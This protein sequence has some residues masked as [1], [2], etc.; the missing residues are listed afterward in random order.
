MAEKRA[1]KINSDMRDIKLGEFVGLLL[2]EFMVMIIVYWLITLCVVQYLSSINLDSNKV[3]TMFAIIACACGL[4]IY[5]IRNK[6]DWYITNVVMFIA[7]AM[8][9]YFG[10]GLAIGGNTEVSFF[11]GFVVPVV[12]FIVL[13]I[14]IMFLAVVFDCT[15]SMTYDKLECESK[16]GGK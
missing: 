11:M 3:F 10:S 13:H 16:D 9:I 12:A 14:V 6:V 2:L 7:A 15:F 4:E 1:K 5:H 8:C